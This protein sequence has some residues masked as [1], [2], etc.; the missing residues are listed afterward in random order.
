MLAI[1]DEDVSLESL[2]LQLRQFSSDRDC[3]QFHSPENLAMAP[4]AES[5]ELFKRFQWVTEEPP[6]WPNSDE[7][8]KI[9]EELAAIVSYLIRTSDKPGIDLFNAAA[10]KT[11]VHETKYPV[12]KSRGS[13]KTFTEL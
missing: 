6:S 1:G 2:K 12:E 10:K 8:Q 11:K 9:Q 4:S 7:M 5:S 3:D 13:A